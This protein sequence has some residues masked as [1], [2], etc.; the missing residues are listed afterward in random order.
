MLRKDS[1]ADGFKSAWDIPQP[2]EPRR[3]MY[4]PVQH[5]QSRPKDAFEMYNS[6]LN[7]SHPGGAQVATEQSPSNRSRQNSN[8]SSD[9]PSYRDLNNPQSSNRSFPGEPLRGISPSDGSR[10]VLLGSSARDPS[11]PK[12][13][14]APSSQQQRGISPPNFYQS[15]A[16]HERRGSSPKKHAQVPQAKSSMGSG[17]TTYQAYPGAAQLAS[18]QPVKYQAFPGGLDSNNAPSKS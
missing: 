13:Y 2:Y 3:D 15:P 6:G 16:V 1:D 10:Q 12:I 9:A 4:D 14:Q 8:T 5:L 7:Y 11:P 18:G 17:Q